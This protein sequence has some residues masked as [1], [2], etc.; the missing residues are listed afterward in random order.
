MRFFLSLAILLGMATVGFAQTGITVDGDISDWNAGWIIDDPDDDGVGAAE[1]TQWGVV[2]DDMGTTDALD[3][4]AYG[5]IQYDT[6]ISSYHSAWAGFWID[7]DNNDATYGDLGGAPMD[8][9]NGTNEWG[10]AFL[11]VD[12]LVEN[13]VG[14]WGE[15]YNFWG[16]VDG[17]LANQGT[18]V[19]AGSVATSGQVMEFG[20]SLAEISQ[21]TYSGYFRDWP[22]S[23]WQI[24]V[25][26]AAHVDGASDYTGDVSDTLVTIPEPTTFGLLAMAGLFALA[27]RRRRK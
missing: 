13:G 20:M 7:I 11:G 24:G 9:T 26:A 3:D 22:G 17:D 4:M 15:G 10:T 2:Y 16:D 18:A 21:V 25:R 8:A 6:D 19:S 5:F 1:M 23:V 27:L 14:I 12:Q